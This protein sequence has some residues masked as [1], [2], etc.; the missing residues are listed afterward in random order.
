MRC[1]NILFPGEEDDD[2]NN[3]DDENDK[4]KGIKTV[5]KSRKG[6]EAS[7]PI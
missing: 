6:Y 5:T 7:I 1:K 3:D 2:D 4:M